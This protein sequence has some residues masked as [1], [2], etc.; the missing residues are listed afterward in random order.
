MV[1]RKGDDTAAEA[2]AGSKR[3]RSSADQPVPPQDSGHVSSAGG[4]GKP[5]RRQVVK[6]AP[7]HMISRSTQPDEPSSIAGPSSAASHVALS[8]PS[9]PT[10]SAE[11]KSMTPWAGT[12]GSKVKWKNVLFERAT[13]SDDT[14]T[15]LSAIGAEAPRPVS[16]ETPVA[17]ASAE[18]FGPLDN[19]ERDK[20]LQFCPKWGYS[21]ISYSMA[22]FTTRSARLGSAV[23]VPNTAV[24]DV[25][26][27]AI[28]K[29]NGHNFDTASLKDLGLVLQTDIRS[30]RDRC[31]NVMVASLHAKDMK[32]VDTNRL[33]DARIEFCSCTKSPNNSEIPK[34]WEQLVAVRLFPASLENPATVFTFRVMKEFHKHM[35][36]S[37]KSAYDYFKALA[38]LTDSVTPQDVTDRYREFQ[39]AY[40]IWRSLALERRTGQSHGIDELVPHRRPGSLTVRCPACLEPGFN[41]SE[42]T[43][44]NALES[45][46]HKFT[47]FLSADGNFKM[48]R[49]NKRD[50]P[51]DVALN[52]GGGYF[53][54]TKEYERYVGLVKPSE[55]SEEAGTCNHLRAAR[56]G[57]VAVQCARHGFYLP[58]GMVDLKKGEAFAL[59]DY[60]LCYSLV[61]AT[62][63]HWV[64][65]TYDIWCQYSIK[66]LERVKKWFPSME[67]IVEMILGAIPKMHIHNHKERC[68]LEW[69]LNWLMYVGL[70][71]REMIET[72][73]VEQNLMAGNTKEQNHGNRHDSIDDTSGHWNWQKLISLMC[74]RE[75]QARQ[76]QFDAFNRTQSPELV[77]QWEAMDV[78]PKMVNGKFESVFQA[79]FKKGEISLSGLRLMRLHT[80]LL[81]QEVE[82]ATAEH[83]KKTGDAAL[84]STGLLVERDQHHVK[85]MAAQSVNDDLLRGARNRLHRDVTDLRTRLI[86]RVPAYEKI[87]KDIDTDKPENEVLFF[88][89]QFSETVRDEMKLAALA[90]VEYVQREGQAFDALSDVRTAIMTFNYNRTIKCSEIHGVGANTC[91]QNY[92]KSLHND[93]I[94]SAD[95]YTRTQEALIA[96]GLPSTD[97]VLQRLV[98]TELYGKG[99]TKQAAGDAKKREPWFWSTGRPAD[100]SAEEV[101]KWEAEVN[102]VKWFR[103]RALRDRAQEEKGMLEQEFERAITW[104]SKTADVWEKLAA[105]TEGAGVKAYAHKQARMYHKLS[106]NCSAEYKI[107]DQRVAQ[108][109]EKQAKAT[110]RQ[111]ER[112]TQE[113]MDLTNFSN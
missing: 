102:R 91:T 83:E 76:E 103:E 1:K 92:L 46:R 2:S 8:L 4:R 79:N 70:T 74:M 101:T 86:Q 6:K 58:Q 45:E 44:R 48:Q 43:I 93:I 55:E 72:G 68:L 34:Y 36:A 53:V 20:R 98:K 106:D 107:L 69:N 22:M 66:L 29:W 12:T 90:Q 97:P 104:F 24:R 47:L 87:M 54:E 56:I 52:Y 10:T 88:P 11:I 62:T 82:A 108:E 32:V 38:F 28:E 78:A 64:F 13:L 85:R 41:I 73:W 89:S 7:A 96:L 23:K 33:H 25:P 99:G 77:K 35:L 105:K 26:F 37:K 50:D 15:H 17:P 5:K 30:G 100:M 65:A 19:K 18:T 61:E 80:Q 49:K 95:T 60:A 27:H 14:D 84:I 42:E 39:F 81:E 3:T 57:V 9:V 94:V 63:Q 109:K 40:R 111:A 75:R 71:I 67:S 110:S 51:D 21:R 31:P 16:P 113:P 112:K 59:T